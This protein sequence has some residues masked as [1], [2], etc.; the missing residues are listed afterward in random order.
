MEDKAEREMGMGVG[1][2]SA[3]FNSHNYT[4]TVLV[5]FTVFTEC[6]WQCNLFASLSAYSEA[7]IDYCDIYAYVS[8]NDNNFYCT[9]NF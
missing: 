5:F 1:F 6:V 4:N 9:D 8:H 2:S 7:I 3:C